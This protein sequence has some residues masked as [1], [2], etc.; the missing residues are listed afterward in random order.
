MNLSLLQRLLIGINNARAHWLAVW[1]IYQES[2]K[3]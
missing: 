1:F 2:R 3:P